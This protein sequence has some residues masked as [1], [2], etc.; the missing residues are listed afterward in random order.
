[1]LNVVS[2][3]Y[4]EQAQEAACAWF[5]APSVFCGD[6]D[7]RKDLHNFAFL[8]RSPRIGTASDWVWYNVPHGPQK[9][10]DSFLQGQRDTIRL[11]CKRLMTW[12]MIR[13]GRV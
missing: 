9:Q 8:G 2:S 7:F 1:M 4:G 5:G 12:I 3:S 6:V 10:L 13:V 11:Q